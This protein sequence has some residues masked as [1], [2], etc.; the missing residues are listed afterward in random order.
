MI[1]GKWKYLAVLST[2]L[3]VGFYVT[4]SCAVDYAR[5]EPTDETFNVEVSGHYGYRGERTE[6]SHV[7][8]CRKV[9]IRDLDDWGGEDWKPNTQIFAAEQQDGSTLLYGFSDSDN[10]PSTLGG[11]DFHCDMFVED[12][13]QT[14]ERR[15][16]MVWIDD[17]KR[18]TRALRSTYFDQPYPMEVGLISPGQ[19]SAKRTNRRD[20]AHVDPIIHWAYPMMEFYFSGALEFAHE[21]HAKHEEMLT[22]YTVRCFDRARLREIWGSGTSEAWYLTVPPEFV[23][24]LCADIASKARRFLP[25]VPERDA[26]DRVVV[27]DSNPDL[28]PFHADPGL[29]RALHRGDAKV[30]LIYKKWKIQVRRTQKFR[31]NLCPAVG[32]KCVVFNSAFLNVSQPAA[33]RLKQGN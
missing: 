24:D 29:T 2:M 26:A 18:P 28:W 17:I 19:I 15:M 32:K 6:F 9:I 3:V 10:D 11:A 30:E 33:T 1:M 7:I 14:I 25:L 5:F 22:G 12:P 21:R 16:R 27:D 20:L 13:S 23:D 8:E 4:R 31:G